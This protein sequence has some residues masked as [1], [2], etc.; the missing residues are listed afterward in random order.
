MASGVYELKELPRGGV[1][2]KG[3]TELRCLEG[4]SAEIMFR[5]FVERWGLS[6]QVANKA[7]SIGQCFHELTGATLWIISGYRTEAEQAGLLAQPDSMAAPASRSTHTT[8][9]ATGFDVG[10]DFD[11]PKEH[12]QILA[13]CARCVQLRWGGGSPLDN[14]G[15]PVDWRHFDT[16]PRT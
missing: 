4:P 14:D 8:Y 1:L 9:P 13:V 5:R 12:K 6:D 2:N 11:P 10:F 15:F 7:L 16:G 3:A